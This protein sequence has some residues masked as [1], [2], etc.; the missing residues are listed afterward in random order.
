MSS[1]LPLGEIDRGQTW[2]A[3]SG[4]GVRKSAFVLFDAPPALEG[5][6]IRVQRTDIRSAPG[7]FRADGR[8]GDSEQDRQGRIHRQ[9]V[10]G[11]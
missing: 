5:R 4:R 11:D 6:P 2:L 9:S 1:G 3:V 10:A 7:Y 8:K